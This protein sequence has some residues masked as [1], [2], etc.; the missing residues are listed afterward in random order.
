MW[1]AWVSSLGAGLVSA[2]RQDPKKEEPESAPPPA[3]VAKPVADFATAM[4][5]LLRT[6]GP[7]TPA[8]EEIASSFIQRYLAHRAQKFKESEAAVIRLAQLVPPSGSVESFTL[9]GMPEDELKVLNHLIDDV[10][11]R[12]EV[13]WYLSGVPQLPGVCLGP[14]L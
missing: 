2:C 11:G 3:P 5:V 10:F 8:D 14:V 13:R 7:W 6:I 9:A 1:W 4:A 12:A